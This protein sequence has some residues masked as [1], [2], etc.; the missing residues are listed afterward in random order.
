MGFVRRQIKFVSFQKS[1]HE[2]SRIS[3]PINRKGSNMQ[4]IVKNITSIVPRNI[5]YCDVGARW[6][7]EEPWKS[8]RAIIDFISFE[9]D[10][11]EYELLLKNKGDRDNIYSYALYSEKKELSLNLTKSRGCSSL[12]KP[13]IEFL[14][15]YP[16]S[17]RFS[18]ENTIS[19]E[20]TS[21]DHLDEEKILSDMDFIKIDVQGAELD[22]LKGGKDF[23]NRNIL[24][25]QVEVEF[26][27]MYQ[28][29]P[30]FSDVDTF[31]RNS[32][33][34]QIQDIRKSYWKYSDGINIGSPKG[35]L[36]FG[37]ALYFRPPQEV[38]SWCQHLDR[39]QAVSKLHMACL[40]GVIYG[41]LDYSL[42]LLNQASIG[43]YFE[44][45]VIN[46]W[47]SLLYQHGKSLHQSSRGA[48]VASS[49]FKYL[50]RMFQPTHGGWSTNDGHNL[51]TRKRFGLF[52]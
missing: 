12:Y 10:K 15:H 48:R 21:L 38:L 11:E 26:Q 18:V 9:P 34:L 40:M 14:K 23:L 1:E 3:Q 31:V 5:S 39:D 42:C 33:G 49:L 20:A 41:Y 29:Q 30:L 46:E 51:G 43:D 25:I 52:T 47:K 17:E 4:N 2:Q 37:D 24:G 36:I 45:A 19:V 13:N 28:N 8:F 16:D 6:G 35:Q 27:S 22:I 44:E 50:Y 32:L 7:I